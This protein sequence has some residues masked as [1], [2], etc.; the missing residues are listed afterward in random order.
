M[1]DP[2][3]QP[4]RV[5]YKGQQF[6]VK[7]R[8]EQGE[9]IIKCKFSLRPIHGKTIAYIGDIKEPFDGITT[10]AY[11]AACDQFSRKKGRTIATVRLIKSLEDRE[12]QVTGLKK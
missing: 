6:V 9:E 1:I 8:Y 12:M 4:V 3:K 5:T 10:T 2:T 11:C 7:Y